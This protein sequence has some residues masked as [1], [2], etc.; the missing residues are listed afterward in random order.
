MRAKKSLGQNF[1]KSKH[2]VRV[3]VQSAEIVPGETVI[4]VGPGKGVL[5]RAL[6][7]AGARVT[8]IEKDDELI[9]VLQD[10]FASEIKNK[11]LTLIHGDVLEVE[12]GERAGHKIVANI[13]YYITGALLRLF[14]SS[15][16]PPTS[17]VVLLEKE[18]AR[19]IVAHD[20][21]ESLLSLSVKAYGTPEYIETVKAMFFSPRPKV[22]SAILRVR[23]ISKDFFDTCTE[24]K[25]FLVLKT[26]FAHKRKMLIRNLEESFPK[27]KIAVAFATCNL[28][29]KTRAENLTLLQWKQLASSL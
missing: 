28:S 15:P 24:E 2:A 6:L 1:L 8:A 13:P 16:H 14:L 22:D 26:G 9:P 4:E 7:D 29:T 27:E 18:V 20:K 10:M 11:T 25:F 17:M 12:I 21:K 3:I 23:K 5:T 19:R